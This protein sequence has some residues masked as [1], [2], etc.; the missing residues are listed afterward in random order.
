MAAEINFQTRDE[1]QSYLRSV[2]IELGLS[3]TDP[4]YA[5]ALDSRD[6][7]ACMRQRFHV[8]SI[9]DLRQGK[10]IADGKL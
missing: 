5:A 3:I 9:G 4:G 10:V 1:V 8:P 7:L 6:H 2:S